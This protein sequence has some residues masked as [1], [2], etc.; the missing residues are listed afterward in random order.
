LGTVIE[1]Q[2]HNTYFCLRGEEISIN[3]IA[4]I[5]IDLLS[6]KVRV[7][8]RFPRPHDVRRHF[9]DISK[10]KKILKFEPKINIQ[11]G[12]KKYLEH[13][14]TTEIDFKAAMKQI[15]ERNW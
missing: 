7:A 2:G 13:L 11:D 10:A 9:A 6:S 12:I 8:H 3:K 14:N 5:V 15:P 1:I 4:K